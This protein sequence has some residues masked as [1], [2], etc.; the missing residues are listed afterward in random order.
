LYPGAKDLRCDPVYSGGY[1]DFAK[2]ELCGSEEVAFVS[3]ASYTFAS[4][5]RHA[6]YAQEYANVST[7]TIGM[8]D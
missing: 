8:G 3:D 2:F 7:Q 1:K 5:N 6:P 4:A